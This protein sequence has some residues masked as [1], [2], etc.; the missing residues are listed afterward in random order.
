MGDLAE[1]FLIFGDVLRWIGVALSPLFL[2][3]I[4]VLAAPS[5]VGRL[6][7]TLVVWLDRF[8]G[9][10]L[11]AAMGAAVLMVVAQLAVVVVRY[12][13]GLAFSWLN[14]IV[15]YS[16]AAMFLL[17]AASALRDQA[18]V[19]VDI[20]RPRFGPR[21]RAVIELLGAYI[22]IFPICLLV[23]WAV[24]PSLARSWAGFE[25]SRESDG[26]PLFFLFR[27]LMPA[28]AAL[29]ALQGLSQALK[30]ALALRGRRAFDEADRDANVGAA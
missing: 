27:T 23:F 21:V 24:E 19:R 12:V 16:F 29:F 3:P 8:S 25:G 18:H 7:E 2:A 1:L 30:A 28:F 15:V 5:I 6:S 20:L 11:G 26:L 10:A 14:E 22:F 9:W 13:F 4:A 17:A